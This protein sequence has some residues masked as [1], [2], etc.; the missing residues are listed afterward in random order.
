SYLESLW[1]EASADDRVKLTVFHV[2][3]EGETRY[4]ASGSVEFPASSTS[5]EV[6]VT[7]L[8]AVL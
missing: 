8:T 1:E 7:S 6:P 3:N 2:W 5:F 4:N